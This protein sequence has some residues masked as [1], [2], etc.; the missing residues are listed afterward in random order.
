MEKN[1][2]CGQDVKWKDG[3][4]EQ[5]KD[6]R[7]EEGTCGNPRAKDPMVVPDP[8]GLQSLAAAGAEHCPDVIRGAEGPAALQVAIRIWTAVP[9]LEGCSPL[10]PRK[11]NIAPASCGVP[12]DPFEPVLRKC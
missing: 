7:M 8:G 5:W 3:R 6:G 9:D 4:R 11:Q 10:Q 1:T 2:E 12:I